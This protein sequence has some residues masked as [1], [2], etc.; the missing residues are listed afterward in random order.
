MF[1]PDS[2][3]GSGATFFSDLGGFCLVI[4]SS[5]SCYLLDDHPIEQLP[6]AD[7]YF[8]LVVMINVL[9][10]VQDAS[11]CMKNVIRV[12]RCGG[13]LIIG[14]DL[15]NAQDLSRHPNGLQTGHPITLDEDWFYPF[16]HGQ[17]DHLLKKVLPREE[18]WAPEWHY[19][20][21]IFAG[22][23]R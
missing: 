3:L 2:P 5:P 7:G 14:Q 13:F 9:D 20:T 15:T 1:C 10:H 12:T 18:G 22:R 23:K 17:F 16:L 4:N 21:L 6:F 19:G 11:A 8:D